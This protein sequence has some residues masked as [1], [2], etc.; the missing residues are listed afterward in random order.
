MSEGG[1]LLGT[2]DIVER[3]G[4]SEP[5]A[6]AWLARGLLPAKKIDG[7]WVVPEDALESFVPPG[8]ARMVPEEI[9]KK[10]IE[11]HGSILA[12]SKEFGLSWRT[13]RR[14]RMEAAKCS[15]E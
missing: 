7:R 13:V 4:V 11:Y 5:T 10:V 3:F 1:K 12:A 14:I 8:K 15:K 9:R 6:R 2:M